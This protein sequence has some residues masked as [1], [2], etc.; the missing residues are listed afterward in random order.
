MKIPD[1]PPDEIE[2]LAALHATG[3]LDT[4]SEE[5][6]DRLTRTAKRMFGVPIALISLVDGQR[7]WFKSGAGL[8][9]SGSARETPR[10]VSFCGHA[11]LGDDVFII[12]DASE[13]Q[14]FLD[15]P[16]VVQAPHVRFYAGCPLEVNGHKLGTLCLIDREPRDFDA[17][18]MQALR[19]LTGMV[20][21]E[22]EAV[23]L[24]TLDELTGISNRR[25]FMLP[26]QQCLRMH[27]R[28]GLAA[29]LVMLDLDHFKRIN[30]NF[31][32]AEGDVALTAFAAQMK[33]TF[34]GSDILCRI[35]GDEFVVL[36]SGTTW[37]VADEVMRRFSTSLQAYN[38]QAGRGYD[39]AYS[40]GAVEFDAARHVD[41]E[42]LLAEGDALMYRLKESRR[43]HAAAV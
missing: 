11:I 21:R 40:H 19:D 36:L 20:E 16:L 10:D 4:A 7:Q 14:R 26:A 13:D 1:T 2:R 18:D 28:N 43:A 22:I 9:V 29:T 32:H 42:T 15:N 39:I 3:I 35:G 24:A 5:R 17:D 8:D 30:D 41:V 23:Q 37:R 25:G 31:G 6:F 33:R 38:H 34:R 27:A 12:P